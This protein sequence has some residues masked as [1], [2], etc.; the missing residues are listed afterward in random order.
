[1]FTGKAV[2]CHKRNAIF[3][4]KKDFQENTNPTEGNFTASA[5]KTKIKSATLSSV[6]NY[7]FNLSLKGDNFNASCYKKIMFSQQSK[8]DIWE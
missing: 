4:K 2:V 1:M 3:D 5:V 7:S 8:I 6:C